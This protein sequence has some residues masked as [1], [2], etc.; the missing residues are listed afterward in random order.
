MEAGL[1]GKAELSLLKPG[2]YVINTARAEVLDEAALLEAL[3]S[4][5]LGGAAL[6]V[7]SVEGEVRRGPSGHA[8]P[9]ICVACLSAFCSC[10]SH[11]LREKVD[12][13]LMP[14]G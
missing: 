8:S 11:I 6:D 10:Y 4:G 12:P 2:A 7:W 14:S 3:E 1:I 5:R 13:L 9:F